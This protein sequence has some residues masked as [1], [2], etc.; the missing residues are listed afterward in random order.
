[1]RRHTNNNYPGIT[2]GTGNAIFRAPLGAAAGV[3][4]AVQLRIVYDHENEQLDAYVNGEQVTGYPWPVPT[5]L[6]I[7]TETNTYLMLHSNANATGLWTDIK[8]WV[9]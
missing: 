3:G 9:E 6:L 2:P 4:K 7:Q 8:V 5:D 1:M